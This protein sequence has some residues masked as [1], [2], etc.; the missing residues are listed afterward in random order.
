MEFERNISSESGKKWIGKKANPNKAKTHLAVNK[1]VGSE[2]NKQ[3]KVQMTQKSYDIL[4]MGT[5]GGVGWNKPV[6]AVR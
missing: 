4:M 2:T 6:T 5:S 1:P 3:E